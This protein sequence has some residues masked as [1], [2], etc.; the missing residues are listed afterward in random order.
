MQPISSCEI[1][2]FIQLSSNKFGRFGEI[3]PLHFQGIW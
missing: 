3:L 1:Q 2:V